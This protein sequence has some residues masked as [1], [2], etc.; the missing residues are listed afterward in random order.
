M[1]A[2]PVFPSPVAIMFAVPTAT[3]VTT[4]VGDTVATA[5][6]S[7]LQPIT[8]PVR[9]APLASSV[10]AVAWDDPTAV[11]ELGTSA[12]VTDATG[13]DVTVRAAVPVFPSLV[14]MIFAVPALTAATTP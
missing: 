10:V 9:V 6:L 11:I 12:T 13:A 8:L 4:P 1:G 14:A 5:V 7:E 3:P 2:L